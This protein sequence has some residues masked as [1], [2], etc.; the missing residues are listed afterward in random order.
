MYYKHLIS[1]GLC[2]WE[3]NQLAN[4]VISTTSQVRRT[5]MTFYSGIVQ[6]KDTYI[7]LTEIPYNRR[8]R[9]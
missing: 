5:P 8:I 4:V 3:I 2:K 6:P 7:P 9:R 1:I